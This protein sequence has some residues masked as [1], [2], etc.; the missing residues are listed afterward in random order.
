MHFVWENLCNCM[1]VSLTKMLN[2]IQ[3]R[4][5]LWNWDLEILTLKI[6][7]KEKYPKARL[8]S[9]HSI[10]KGN[11]IGVIFLEISY[12]VGVCFWKLT[13]FNQMNWTSQP[14]QSV[15]NTLKNH[16]DG[17]RPTKTGWNNHP[18]SFLVQTDRRRLLTHLAGRIIS[19]KVVF[20]HGP[21]FSVWRVFINFTPNNEDNKNYMSTRPINS[22]KQSLM[23]KF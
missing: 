7:R 5:S 10:Q 18:D 4:K 17:Y 8:A 13:L 21:V 22:E 23:S 11:P 2:Q 12:G 9:K 20:S 6:F 14:G 3:I 1:H 16:I 15:V 19:I